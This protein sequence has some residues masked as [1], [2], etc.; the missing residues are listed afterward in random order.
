M[1]R[2]VSAA[3]IFFSVVFF[4]ITTLGQVNEI[5]GKTGEMTSLGDSYGYVPYLY[6]KVI[7]EG[8]DTNAKLPKVAIGYTER[9]QPE[10]RMI[11]DKSGNYCF[12][13]TS[14]E[15][16]ATLVVYLEGAEV[17]RRTIASLGAAQQREDF[18]VRSGPSDRPAPPGTI[19]AKYNYPPNDKTADLY[20]K[21][22]DAEKEKN[23]DRV[24]EFVKEIVKV[25]PADFIAW[26]KLGLVYFDKKSYSDAEA[27]Y[28]KSLEIRPDFVPAMANLGRTYIA[29]IK[30]E[31]ALQILQKATAADPK[32]AKA[33]QYLGT[34]YLQAKKGSLGV[35]ALNKAIELDPVGCADAHLLMA[36][37]YDRAGAKDLASHEY[38]LF[39]EKVPTYP[40]KKKFEQYIKDNPEK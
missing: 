22:L 29:Q 17:G 40:E 7:L 9:G 23:P 16:A 3:F 21:A 36:T 37:L 18:E 32:Y 34:A 24:I 8:F 19:S 5:C 31:P 14:A 38:R 12:R 33:F 1:K 11:L 35:A 2:A 28:R 4:S 10:K 30:T 6:G 13:R 26:A 15:S 25:D 39:I 20:K 27:A